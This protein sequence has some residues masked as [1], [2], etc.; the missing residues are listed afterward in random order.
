MT[1][2]TA[3]LLGLSHPKRDKFSVP[4][5]ADALIPSVIRYVE[6]LRT[7]ESRECVSH[8]G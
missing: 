4:P 7:P 5:A 1:T 3:S 6:I 2:A 8:V